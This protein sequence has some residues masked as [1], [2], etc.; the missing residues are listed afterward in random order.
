MYQFYEKN[1]DNLQTFFLVIRK[2]GA[3]KVAM[4][5]VSDPNL[6]CIFYFI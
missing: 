1:K 5:Y 3:T 2:D 4:D 6:N